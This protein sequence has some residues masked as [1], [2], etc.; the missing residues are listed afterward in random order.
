MLS[1]AAEPANGEVVNTD[2][3]IVGAGPAG[4]TI[5]R[6]LMGTRTRICLL[7]SGGRDV[8]R[9]AQ[10]HNRGESVG[11]PIRLSRSRVRAF[12]GSSRLWGPAGTSRPLGLEEGLVV[13]PLDLIDFESRPGLPWSGWPF[14]RAHLEPWYASAQAVCQAGPYDYDPVGWEGAGPALPLADD[15]VGTTVFVHGSATFDGYHAEVADAPNITLLQ[16]ATV[17]EL[18]PDDQPDR[19]DRVRVRRDDGSGYFVK[20]RVVVLAAGGIENPRL[21]LLSCRSHPTGL[22]NRYDLVGRYFAERLSGRS[23]HV[24]ADRPELIDQAGF[25]GIRPARGTRVQGAFRVA[26]AVQR[27]RQL[28]NCA[29]FLLKRDASITA[30]G[31]R[32]VATLVKAAGRRP[33]ATDV[34]GHLRNIVTGARSLAGL[35]AGSIATRFGGGSGRPQVL[36]L[37]VQGEQAP[38]ADSRITLGERT[39]DFGL[40]VARV[41]WRIDAADRASIRTSQELLDAALRAAGLGR[42]EHML[43]AEHPPMLFEGNHHHLGATRM[44]ADPRRGVVDAD[45]K[46]HG[47]RNVYVAGSSVFPTYG[48]SNPTLTIVALALRLADHIGTQLGASGA[49]PGAPQSTSGIARGQEGR[50]ARDRDQRRF[51]DEMAAEPVDGPQQPVANV[52]DGLPPEGSARQGDVGATDGGVV[53]G[54]VDKDDL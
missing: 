33:L 41:D 52:H 6:E 21:L 32:S 36:V 25:Y 49:P 19:V 45:L 22:G 2:L 7:D 9:R 39:D 47:V 46:I 18:L 42:V 26:D 11:Y 37:R 23:G 44:H 24:V 43:G 5:A 13:R 10:R 53:L 28:R 1:H 48:S 3:C 27:E 35:A 29:F 14:D 12:G 8:E 15:A 31:V 51:E 30:E 34:S 54:T 38:N 16:H 50:F 20:A 40:P 17:T 4:I